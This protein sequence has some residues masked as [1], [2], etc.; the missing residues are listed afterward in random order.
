MSEYRPPK[1]GYSSPQFRWHQ[2]SDG[3]FEAEWRVE[4]VAPPPSVIPLALRR[5]EHID[6]TVSF[7]HDCILEVKLISR[8][9]P[10]MPHVFSAFYHLIQPAFDR[11]LI[12]SIEGGPLP[13]HEFIIRGAAGPRED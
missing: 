5:A 9:T 4:L 10:L 7:P 12:L 2:R 6:I 8:E 1:F 3:C 13:L 11:G